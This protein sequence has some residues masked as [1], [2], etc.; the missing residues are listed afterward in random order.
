M[1]TSAILCG[2]ERMKDILTK[3]SYLNFSFIIQKKGIRWL[4]AKVTEQG[5]SSRVLF[6]NQ[7][8][9]RLYIA[10]DDELRVAIPKM[11]FWKL[12]RFL[13]LY[14]RS[15]GGMCRSTQFYFTPFK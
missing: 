15:K 9:F 5:T 1:R 11:S 14:A 13:R 6:E 12:K 4:K 10:G 2:C 7:K 8:G 3:N